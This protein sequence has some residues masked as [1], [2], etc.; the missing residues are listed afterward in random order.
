MRDWKTFVRSRL[1]LPDLTPERES[2]IVRELAA[3]LEDFYR[4]AVGRG[5]SAAEADA[6]AC[7]Q[8]SDW[9]RMADDLL[10]ADRPHAKARAD[11]LADS[12]QDAMPAGGRRRGGGLFMLANA[13]RDGRYAIRQ[14]RKTPGFTLVAVLTLALG[15][16]ATTA[17][18]TV[19][20]SVLLRPLPYPA[21]EN[22][23]RVHEIVPEYGRF[24]VAPA[25]FLD[26]RQQ[27]DV[28]ERIAAYTTTSGT[29]LDADGPERIQGAAVSWDLFDL[30]RVTPA[31][32]SGFVASQDLPNANNVIVIS[33]GFWQRRFAGDPGVVGRSINFNN[34]PATIVGIMP[35]GFYFPSR[36]AE[37]WQPI[38]LSPANPS[39]G[40]HFLGVI[41]RTKP[42]V[43]LDQA[44]V[45]MRTIAV[46]LAQRYPDD[47]A[48]QSAEVVP[49]LEQIVGA[50]RPALLTLLAAVAVVVLI[51]CANVANLL[52]V[53]AS[54]REKEVA[55]R[56]ALGAGRRRLAVQMLVES[57]LLG[58]AG[59]VIGV[60][61]A[62]LAIP[63]VQQLGAN[64]I[65]RVADIALDTRVLGVTFGASLLT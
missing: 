32:G 38:A 37:F 31:A 25:T 41:A 49:L 29:L 63:V 2:R 43:T 9:R 58:L 59:G 44:N 8:I 34:A 28:F 33:H 42:G 18:F 23:V 20:N 47:A 24:S 57:V 65:P 22:L 13:V 55:I 17:I 48:D 10:R 3:Q 1:T 14:L 12:L 45:A 6:H 52:L 40:A 19:V 35:P 30:L 64:S 39:R 21:A 62:Y 4:E 7:A 36:I 54:V 26:W 56:A 53:R 5:A 50:V 51:A 46:R 61:L 11:R 15:I 27:N 16:G 60:L